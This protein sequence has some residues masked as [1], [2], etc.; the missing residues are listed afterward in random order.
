MTVEAGPGLVNVRDFEAAARDRLDPV[1]HD[2]FASGAQDEIT[3]AANESAFRRRA[4]IPRVLRGCTPPRLEQAMSARTW[5]PRVTAAS[6]A[7]ATSCWSNRK[8]VRS[9]VF[10]A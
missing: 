1:Y 6:S 9:I 2:Y 7:L 4:L 5:T 3:V 10:F 8:M